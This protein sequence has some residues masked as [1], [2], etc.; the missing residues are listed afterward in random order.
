MLQLISFIVS[1]CFHQSALSQLN[2]Q[3]VQLVLD[4]L[5]WRERYGHCAAQAYNNMV[6][7]IIYLTAREAESELQW[8]GS[9]VPFS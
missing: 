7:H 5:C 9:R 6:D 2:L 8:A 4:E 1:L 3:Q